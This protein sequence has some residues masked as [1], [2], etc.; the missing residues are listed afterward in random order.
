MNG[1]EGG[2]HAP[3]GPGEPNS[4]SAHAS[5]GTRAFRFG[6]VIPV[7]VLAGL[8]VVGLVMR[9]GSSPPAA[10]PGE[11]TAG[12]S[13]GPTTVYVPGPSEHPRTFDARGV[14]FSYPSSWR[15]APPQLKALLVPG[16]STWSIALQDDEGGRIVVAAYPSADPGTQASRAR[17]ANGLA[18]EMA[19]PSGAGRHTAT[20]AAAIYPAFGYAI[21]RSV[22]PSGVGFVVFTPRRQYAIGC[23]SELSAED[24]GVR[25][26]YLLDSFRD[27]SSG[28]SSFAPSIR[29]VADAVYHA[30]KSGAPST[31][32]TFAT[33]DALRSLAGSQW[34]PGTT[35]PS[36]SA[37]PH[38]KDLFSCLV[39]ENG[40]AGKLFVVA[41]VRGRFAVVAIGDCSGDLT[42]NTCYTLRTIGGAF[43]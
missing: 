22:N 5:V 14:F 25:C 38:R 11:L 21:R 9:R 26:A 15:S 10:N 36:C 43:P 27:T 31:A 4:D 29:S 12:P 16:G 35:R 30:W 19:P 17:V 41:P 1:P 18:R 33:A 23:W 39:A 40:A 3:V 8:L 34:T 2:S 37:T 7:V 6:G 24:A 32:G 13:V 20:S 42:H 28:I